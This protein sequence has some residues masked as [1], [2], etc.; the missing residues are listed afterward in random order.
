[1]PRFY[2]QA[3]LFY[4]SKS[5]AFSSPKH[6]QRLDNR[7]PFSPP[8]PPFKFKMYGTSNTSPKGTFRGPGRGRSRCAGGSHRCPRARCVN[9]DINTPGHVYLN[10]RDALTAIDVILAKNS[11]EQ[12]Q[13]AALKTGHVFRIENSA[14]V[15]YLRKVGH[16]GCLTRVHVAPERS[17]GISSL[18]IPPATNWISGLPYLAAVLWGIAVL[19]LLVLSQDWRG[20]AVVGI[21]IVSRLVNIIV[22]WQRTGPTWRGSEEDDD[23]GDLLIILS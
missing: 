3:R 4:Q 17:A 13:C 2:Y 6:L 23:N 11:G 8:R 12:P 10:S 16:T 14:L 9:R 22:M 18:F 19:V 1:M 21:L 15:Y 20:V 7:V 5:P